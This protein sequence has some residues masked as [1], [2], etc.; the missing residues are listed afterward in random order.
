MCHPFLATVLLTTV[1]SRNRWMNGPNYLVEV[2][3][4]AKHLTCQNA[5]WIK[6]SVVETLA[7]VTYPNEQHEPSVMG[8]RR[9]REGYGRTNDEASRNH[10][11]HPATQPCRG[12]LSASNNRGAVSPCR[13]RRLV[14]WHRPQKAENSRLMVR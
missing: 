11:I 5:G 14:E 2:D 8:S 4:C 7:L 6:A 13:N 3:T 1:G 9:V 12:T 10:P